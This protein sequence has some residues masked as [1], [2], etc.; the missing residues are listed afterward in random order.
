MN[1]R[2][3]CV[4]GGTG[5]VGTHVVARLAGGGRQVKVIT[6]HVSRHRHLL[7]VPGVRLVEA[8]CHDPRVLRQ[9]F[10]DCDGVINLVG[11]LN[12][13]GRDG[14][15][16]RHA[17]VDLARK[18][19]E[20]AREAGVKRLLHMSAL[21]ADAAS[22]PSHY[23]RTKGEAENIVHTMAGNVRVTSFRPS[24]IFGPTDSFFNRFA[25]LLRLSPVLPLACP[26]ARFAPVYVGDVAQHFVDALEDRGTWGQ[27]IELCGPSVYTLKELVSYTAQVM[28]RRRLILGLSE[29]LSLWQARI[30]EYVPGKPFSLDNYHSMSRDS[31]CRGGGGCPTAIEAIVPGYLGDRE[32][33]ARLQRLRSG[34]R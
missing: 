8:D 19:I 4:L 30:M 33:H 22:G 14:S 2:T 1:I 32:R 24:V 3:I 26:D 29:G 23:L 16:F 18:V 9:H 21:N 5:F 31:V 34:P 13:R 7:V 11:I 6:R 25:G 20:C 17:H 10:S 15:G 27:R 28:A 12:E